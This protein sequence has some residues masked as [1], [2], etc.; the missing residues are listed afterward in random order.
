MESIMEKLGERE[1]GKGDMSP[2][3][4][5]VIPDI[6]KGKGAVQRP[7][8]SKWK[9]QKKTGVGYTRSKP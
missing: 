4:G 9:K 6:H 1:F 2:R 5:R 3:Q 8:G 7:K